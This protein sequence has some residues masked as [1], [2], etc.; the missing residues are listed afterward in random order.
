[1]KPSGESNSVVLPRAL[2]AEVEAAADAEHRPVADVVRELAEQG[3]G[4]R[5][6]GRRAGRYTAPLPGESKFAESVRVLRSLG[7]RALASA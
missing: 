6:C 3:L 7:V 4:E 5:R 2:L 1:M